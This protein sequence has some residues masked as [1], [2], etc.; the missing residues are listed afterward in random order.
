SEV[1]HDALRLAGAL[2]A[3]GLKRG[4]VV[5]FQL[6]NWYEA[7]LVDIACAYGGF[8]C[9]P[10]VPIYRGAEVGFIIK[11]SG[12]R[13]LFIPEHFRNFDYK[14]MADELWP[15]WNRLDNV[16]VVRGSSQSAS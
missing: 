7:I 12:S 11:D 1:K 9:N 8:V 5:S 3:K 14:A 10:I 4:D 2:A 13:I 6:P 15:R 16:I